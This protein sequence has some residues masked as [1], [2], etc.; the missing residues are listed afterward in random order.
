MNKQELKA[1]RMMLM[2]AKH[3]AKDENL[4]MPLE[5]EQIEI[6][7]D[8]QGLV[9]ALIECIEIHE[10]DVMEEE[11]ASEGRAYGGRK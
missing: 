11:V 2:K 7:S 9:D 8:A 3:A 6:L 10:A 1:L 5:P 4:P